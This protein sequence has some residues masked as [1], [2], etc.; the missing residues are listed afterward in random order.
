[1]SGDTAKSRM[2]KKQ[3]TA[4]DG[5]Y[6]RG[7]RRRIERAVVGIQAYGVSVIEA[8]FAEAIKEEVSGRRKG[9]GRND[10]KCRPWQHAPPGDIA[11][12]LDGTYCRRVLASTFRASSIRNDRFVGSESHG[13]P[14][15]AR[16]AD[17]AIVPISARASAASL[18]SLPRG[19][20]F[21]P[22]ARWP[23]WTRRTRG[24]IRSVR[25]SKCAAAFRLAKAAATMQIGRKR[26]SRRNIESPHFSLS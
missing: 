4:R 8:L 17:L 15:F 26:G 22:V 14:G 12:D 13:L 7:S 6:Q 2:I 11:R 5:R 1:M 3:P 9:H 16:A 20:P 10:C 18:V 21:P 24:S 19:A 23:A 25:V